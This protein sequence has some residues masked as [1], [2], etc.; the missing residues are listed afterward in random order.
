V[1]RLGAEFFRLWKSDNPDDEFVAYSEVLHRLHVGS[2]RTHDELI[3]PLVYPWSDFLVNDT[4]KEDGHVSFA[5]SE[6]AT[7]RLWAG[8]GGTRTLAHHDYRF[9][10]VCCQKVCVF[11]SYFVPA[12]IFMSC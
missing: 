10:C 8:S 9:V 4:R 5:S 7:F 3:W 6:S 2:G 1:R 12:T 11:I